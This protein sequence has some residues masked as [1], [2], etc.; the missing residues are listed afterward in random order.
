[1]QGF[2]GAILGFVVV[3]AKARRI[4]VDYA[5][6][7]R[8]SRGRVAPRF[9]SFVAMLR[10]LGSFGSRFWMLVGTVCKFAIC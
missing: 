4:W 10:V 5:M 3:L 9:G 6:T 7:E 1:M 2:H 8:G